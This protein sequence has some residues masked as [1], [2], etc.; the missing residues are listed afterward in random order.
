MISIVGDIR[1]FGSLNTLWHIDEYLWDSFGLDLSQCMIWR[2]DKDFKDLRLFPLS[3]D[4][5]L[6]RTQLYAYNAGK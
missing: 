6:K 2:L 5:I 4:Q 1:S 3:S